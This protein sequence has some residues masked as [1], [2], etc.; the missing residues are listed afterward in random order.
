MV[1]LGAEKI[2]QAREAQ[3]LNAY[4][5]P[6][7]SGRI[8]TSHDTVGKAEGLGRT[9]RVDQAYPELRWNSERFGLTQLVGTPQQE[10]SGRSPV[11]LGCAQRQL[12]KV[13]Y[14]LRKFL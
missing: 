14:L 12:K 10:A 9:S 13:F 1:I 7:S 4:A 8:S 5:A 11:C 3:H 2:R 6:Q